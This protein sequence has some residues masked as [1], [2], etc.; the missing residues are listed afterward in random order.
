[1]ATGI[2]SVPLLFAKLWSV[3]P[4]LFRPFAFTDAAAAVERL[5]LVPLVGG[6][7]FLVVTGV[8]NIDLW[9]PW[10]FY[11]PVAH[12]AI[13]WVTIGA[14]LVHITA[15]ATVTRAALRRHPERREMPSEGVTRRRFLGVV[16]G[17]SALLTAV[18]IGQTVWPARLFAVLAPRRPDTGDAGFPV[19]RTA[20]EASVTSVNPEDTRLDVRSGNLTV[21][22]FTLDDLAALP[23]REATLPIACVEGWSASRRW[24]GVSVGDVLAAAGLS[25]TRV[26][27]VSREPV[28]R[29][30]TST[31]AGP[32]LRDRDTLLALRVDGAPL[33]LDHGAPIRLVAPNRPGVLQTKWVA[34][35]EVV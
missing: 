14:L 33:T 27:V 31:L 22:S 18:T 29:Y 25:A 20:A 32:E 21:R 26:E 10:P 12:H 1:V 28:G 17:T 8:A 13:A 3:Y 34:A 15:K 35:L 16:A 7:V 24:S 23:V 5:A 9:Y 2:A 11:F 6:S 19:N 4:H 30:R